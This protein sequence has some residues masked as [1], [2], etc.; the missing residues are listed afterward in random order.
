MNERIQTPRQKQVYDVIFGTETLS[1]RAFD[2]LLL[3]AILA[4][5]AVIMLDSIPT[6]HSA[7]GGLF[8]RI[9]VFFTVLF[10]AEYITRIWCSAN[11]SAYMRSM[12]GIVDLLSILPTYIAFFVPEAAPLLVVRLLRMLR[13]F[14]I[15]RLLELLTEFTNILDV[16]KRS[17]KSI[18]VFFSLVIIV[19]IIFGCL[20]YV[21]EG[22]EH[23][24]TSIPL[25]IYWAIVT[26]TTVGYG[27]VVPQTVA[28]RAISAMGMLTGYA[29]IAVPSAIMTTKLWQD[30]MERQ[31]GRWLH[32]NC[33]QC[34]QGGHAKDADYCKHCGS[35]L[36]VPEEIRHP[37][38]DTR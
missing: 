34:A 3:V 21:L 31:E 28:G 29:I 14:R 8:W 22:P 17:A 38:T 16:M 23:G 27:D 20:I 6:M 24:F 18:F 13:I 35:S 26:I 10:T 5:V 32:W 25:S 36:D 11:R 1:G 15:L 37:P 9:E 30:I 7:S 2:I 19:T 33:P 12:F 4:S